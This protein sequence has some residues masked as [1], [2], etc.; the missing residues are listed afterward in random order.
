MEKFL[1]EG[2]KKVDFDNYQ[3]L[4]MTQQAFNFLYECG[5]VKPKNTFMKI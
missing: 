3:I 5:S 4:E 1:E 2:T